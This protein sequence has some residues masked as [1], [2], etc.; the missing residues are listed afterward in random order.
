MYSIK[1]Y[2]GMPKE[3]SY[4]KEYILGTLRKTWKVQV[5]K[6]LFENNKVFSATLEVEI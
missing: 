3:V 5:E 2:F 6:V 1:Q 4:F